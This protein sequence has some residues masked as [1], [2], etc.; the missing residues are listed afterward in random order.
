F[1]HHN[2]KNTASLQLHNQQ[3]AAKRALREKQAKSKNWLKYCEKR[4]KEEQ[5]AAER[6]LKN[7]NTI[8]ENA[9]KRSWEL[10]IATQTVKNGPGEG[11]VMWARMPERQVED[12]PKSK[13]SKMKT[14][15]KAQQSKVK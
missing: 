7:E 4:M 6:T 3:K 10:A 13:P 14:K 11:K 1:T 9:I 2:Q 12:A 15:S 8:R 5:Q